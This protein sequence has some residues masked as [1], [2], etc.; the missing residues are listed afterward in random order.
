LYPRIRILD[1]STGD[2]QE[3]EVFYQEEGE[4]DHFDQYTTQGKLTSLQTILWP[5]N[6]LARLPKCKAPQEQGTITFYFML[7][8]LF[9]SFTLQAFVFDYL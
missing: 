2:Y 9:P 8:I 4:E 3:E 7:I 6:I 1:A 5:A